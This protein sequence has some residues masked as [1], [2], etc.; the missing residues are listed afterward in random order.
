M[1]YVTWALVQD[2]KLYLAIRYMVGST[3]KVKFIDLLCRTVREVLR[4][5]GYCVPGCCIVIPLLKNY[6][7]PSVAV[8]PGMEG[9][10]QPVSRNRLSFAK[11]QYISKGRCPSGL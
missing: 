8:I 9:R 7:M 5:T 1:I 11:G 2:T 10:F 3:N 6:V 4:F